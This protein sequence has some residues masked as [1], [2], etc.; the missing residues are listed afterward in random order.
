MVY[1][2]HRN[3]HRELG[4]LRRQRNMFKMKEQNKTSKKE[5][6]KMKMS[7]LPNKEFKIKIIKILTELGR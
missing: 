3:N 6:S 1:I 7:N 4:I 2:M 5:L